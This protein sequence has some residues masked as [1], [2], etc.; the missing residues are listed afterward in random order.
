LI[1]DMCRHHGRTEFVLENRGAYR[2]RLCRSEAVTRR[3][4]AVKLSLIEEAGGACV[5]CGY[6][7]HPR[8]LEFHHPDPALK[9]FPV[10]NGGNS[11]A[12]ERLRVEA[13]KCVLLCANCHAEVEAGVAEVP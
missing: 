12:I 3:R 1:I 13:E 9:R 4:Q 10:S 7:R 2:C 6:D 5:I 11:I 8:A